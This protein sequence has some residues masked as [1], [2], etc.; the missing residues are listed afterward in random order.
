MISPMRTLVALILAAVA[1]AFAQ[2]PDARSL[3]SKYRVDAVFAR[4]N[5]PTSPGCAVGVAVKGEVILT[6]AYGMADLE[7]GIPL[8]PV[9][10]FEPGSVTKQFT[11][12]AVLL[13]AEQGK[14]SIDDPVRKYIPELPDYGQPLTIRHLLNHTSGLRDWG[15]IAAISGWPRGARAHTH[16]HV[17]EIVSRQKALN[18]APG[19]DYSYTNTGYNLAAILVGRVA[20]KPLAEFTRE[21]IFTPLGMSKTQWRDDY[22]RIVKD[23]AI[24]YSAAGD[25]F[26]LN[27]PFEFVHGNG[28]LLT[29]IPD[30]LR[31]QRNF[32][33]KKV[34]GQALYDA[35]H[36][37]A[38]LND[39]STIAYAGGLNVLHWRG[40]TEVSHSGSTAGYSAWLGR[41]PDRGVSVAVMCNVAVNATQLGHSV[42]EIYLPD[43]KPESLPPVKGDASQAGMYRSLRDNSVVTVLYEN[44]ELRMGN[45]PPRVEVEGKRIRMMSESDTLVYEKVEPWKPSRAEMEALRGEYSSDEAETAFTV[46]FDGDNFVLRQRPGTFT[47]LSPT[48]RDAFSSNLG[49]VR[50]LRDASGK[51]TGLSLGESR[52]WDLRFSRVR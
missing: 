47:R 11:A 39:G 26:R 34:G 23:R 5:N 30:L 1:F 46:M 21:A 4:Y 18:Y 3:Q 52:V 8:S 7:H 16:E 32:D 33:E 19:A 13:L 14:L 24:A 44:G 49:S 29:T 31:W 22:R 20:G 17:L 15:N 51:V 25:G 37:Q 9:S 42:A 50:F 27:M 12:A 38:R 6:L 2:P 41:Y 48:F 10:V 40:L 36:Q 45:R 28:G 35:Q 43:A